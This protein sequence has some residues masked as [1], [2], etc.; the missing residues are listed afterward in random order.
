LQNHNNISCDLLDV[1][2][3]VYLDDILV[4]SDDLADHTAHVWEV[5]HR[6]REAGLYCKLPKCE[7][8]V[9]TTEYLGYI[10][11]PDGFWMAPDKISAVVEWPVPQKVKDVQSFLGFCNFYRRFIYD[12][13]AIT[14]PLTQLTRKNVIWVWMDECQLAFDT[15]KQAFMEALVLHH[16]V[17]SW[18]V[19]IESDASDYTITAILSITGDNGEIHLVAFRSRSLQPAELNYDTHDKELLAIFDTFTHWH[20]YLEGASFPVDVVTDHKNLEYFATSKVLTRRQ[21][22]WSEYLC[23]FNMVIRW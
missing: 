8:S 19:T 15:L 2:V 14:I 13:A 20:H 18:Q 23:H 3:I 4:Y 10:L 12:Y 9:T 21:V 11:L 17:P 6:L 5:L 7:F 1:T 22:R 16:W